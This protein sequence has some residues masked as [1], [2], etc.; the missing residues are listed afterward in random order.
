MGFDWANPLKLSLKTQVDPG[1][2]FR[3][4]SGEQVL[5]PGSLFTGWRKREAAEAEAESQRKAEAERQRNVDAAL[6]NGILVVTLPKAL[7]RKASN[8]RVKDE[9]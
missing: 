1:N 3:G 8:I 9:E 4:F 6:K 7:T 5:D 2:I